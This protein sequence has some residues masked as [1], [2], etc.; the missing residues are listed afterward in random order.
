MFINI[1]FDDAGLGPFVLDYVRYET[2]AK[3]VSKLI[4]KVLYNKWDRLTCAAES[5]RGLYREAI[6]KD[7]HPFPDATREVEEAYLQIAQ[8][9]VNR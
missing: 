5:S 1:L 3:A 8:A 7:L 6:K 2:A 9:A 4:K